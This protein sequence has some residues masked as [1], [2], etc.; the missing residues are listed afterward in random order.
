MQLEVFMMQALQN[1]VNSL[2][3]KANT[4][5]STIQNNASRKTKAKQNKNFYKKSDNP[6]AGKFRL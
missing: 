6:K 2:E 5:E 3:N 1:V 4:D